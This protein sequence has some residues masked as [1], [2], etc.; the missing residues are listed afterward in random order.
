MEIDEDLKAFLVEGTETL[1]HLEG[2]LVVLEQHPDDPELMNRIYRALHTIKGNC[3][4]L[5][6][7]KLESIAHAA[8]NLLSRLRDRELTLIPAIANA[9]LQV[10][11]AIRQILVTLEST[12]AEGNTDFSALIETLEQL[13]APGKS[14]TRPDPEHQDPE[15]TTEP[16]IWLATTPEQKT[17]IPNKTIAPVPV[18]PPENLPTPAQ[19]QTSPLPQ[20]TDNAPGSPTPPIGEQPQLKETSTPSGK[21]SP[22]SSIADSAIRVNIDLLDK[23]MNLVGELVLCRNQILEF[24]NRQSNTTLLD[25]SQ[26]LNLVTTELQEGIM[27][28]RMQPIRTIW[29]R[30]PRVVRDLSLSLNKHVHLEMEGEETELDKSLIEAIADPLTHLVRNAIDHGI[31][32]PQIRADAGKPVEGRLFLRAFHESGYVNIEIADDGAGIDAETLKVKAVQQG[33]IASER[34]ALM[35]EQDMLNLIFLPGIS[36]AKHITNLSGRGV[37]LDV[38]RTNIEKIGG[39]ID[40]SS[41]RNRGTSFKLKI[42]LT[43]AIIPTLVVSS[44]GERYA[45]PQVNLLELVR[46]EGDRALQRVEMVHGAPVYRL[47]GNL[48]PLVYLN[49][50]LK[51]QDGAAAPPLQVKVEEDVLNIVVLQAAE[52]PFGLVV[53]TINDTQEIVVKPLGKQLKGISCF[54]G[55]TIMGDGKVAL[56]L[57][58]QGLA[59]SAHMVSD[60]DRDST[61][62]MDQGQTQP[63]SDHRQM[64][65]LCQGPD[66]RRLAIP[67]SGVARL[68]QFPRNKIERLGNQSV[69]Q[70]RDQILPLIHLSAVLS[71][72]SNN[73]LSHNADTD[74]V[75][76]VVVSTSNQVTVGLV[77]EQILD[78]VEEEITVRGPATCQEVEC[79]AVVQGKVT[80][81]LSLE[82]VLATTT[83]EFI[84]QPAIAV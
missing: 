53:D 16:I 77:V 23:L 8:E 59:Q 61:L 2:D 12:G 34:A 18:R 54:A 66:R 48:L 68:E 7:E 24:A 78:I 52:K 64:L 81:I 65:L 1:N 47:R 32:M 76:V 72:H 43:L 9:L 27:K 41:Q 26:R 62:G 3:G 6:F 22:S 84:Q 57:D 82:R 79:S 38:V 5:G 73:T 42:P 19:E 55:A 10:I 11:D 35:T 33:T 63:V 44:G 83:V 56:I 46:L 37:G 80:E 50:E 71:N 25:T 70:Y 58:V 20:N 36:T 29:N 69:I 15:D 13:Q 39:T 74:L 75:Q 31:E 40:L 49:R 17:S 51:L 21:T 14:S 28:T 45:I 4:F 67:L 30:F 60:K